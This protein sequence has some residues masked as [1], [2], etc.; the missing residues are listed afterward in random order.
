MQVVEFQDFLP[1]GMSVHFIL[2][3]KD[4]IR[5]VQKKS[6]LLVTLTSYSSCITILLCFRLVHGLT[7]LDKPAASAADKESDGLSLA[8][9]LNSLQQTQ[10]VVDTVLLGICL[11]NSCIVCPFTDSYTYTTAYLLLWA[12]VLKM[13]GLAASDLRYQYAAMLR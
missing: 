13:C 3:R 2:Y 9:L 12:A 4:K 8:K 6:G 5:T 1:S 7:E 11:G 10:T